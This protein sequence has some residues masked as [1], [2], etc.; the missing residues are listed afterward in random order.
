MIDMHGTVS[1]GASINGHRI[2]YGVAGYS[3]DV[4]PLVFDT[5]Y[6]L[7]NGKLTMK[8]DLKLNGNQLIGYT[9]PDS[10]FS[11]AFGESRGRTVR[12]LNLNGHDIYGSVES[13]TAL[14]S[15]YRIIENVGKTSIFIPYRSYISFIYAYA[16]G[17]YSSH[18][19][20]VVKI[21][22]AQME[23]LPKKWIRR[24]NFSSKPFSSKKPFKCKIL[25]N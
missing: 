11:T 12:Y 18:I 1:P 4:D 20:L 15:G 13:S 3:S 2:V 24:I 22:R 7:K 23:L 6:V 21:L 25:N 10:G 17:V 16:F 14:D 9:P 5:A 8:I 19:S